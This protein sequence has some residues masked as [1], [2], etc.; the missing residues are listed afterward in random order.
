MS[1]SE[2]QVRLSSLEIKIKL[3][4]LKGFQHVQ[5]NASGYFGHMDL[6]GKGIEEDH[7]ESL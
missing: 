7:R 5:N 6:A 1:T 4:R 2:E 3:E